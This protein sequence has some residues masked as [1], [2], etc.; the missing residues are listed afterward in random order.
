MTPTLLLGG[1]GL[2]GQAVAR[3]LTRPPFD[4]VWLLVRRE[5]PKS[6]PHHQLRVVN[7]TKLR[8]SCHDIDLTEGCVICALGT[9]LRKAGSKAAFQAIDRDRVVNC[10]Q[11][12]RD[13]GAR[14]FLYVSSLGADPL[15]RNLYLRTKGE[16]EQELMTLGYPRLTL[17]RPSLLVGTRREFRAAERVGMAVGRMMSPLLT[18]PLRR[19]RPV[20]VEQVATV[21][22][23][24]ARFT[25]GPGVDI[26][27]SDRISRFAPDN[28]R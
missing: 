28:H 13:S 18:G 16:T 11:W 2:V 24:Q 9:T 20:P 12:A 26:W 25:S 22:V 10:A 8:Q 23:E 3:R 14:H 6:Q 15:S 1:T 5:P 17:L 4:P 7:F 27:E 19:Y 21:L